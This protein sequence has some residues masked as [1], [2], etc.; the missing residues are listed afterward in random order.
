MFMNTTDEELCD[1]QQVYS[2]GY[3]LFNLYFSIFMF[4]LCILSCCLW[5]IFDNKKYPTLYQRNSWELLE[6]EQEQI[7][8]Q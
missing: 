8:K 5:F 1:E 2:E 3:M 4:S 7:Q 6:Q